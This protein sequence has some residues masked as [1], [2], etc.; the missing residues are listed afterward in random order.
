MLKFKG[1]ATEFKEYEDLLAKKDKLKKSI[2]NLS[3]KIQDE[4]DALSV[5]DGG[6]SD[7][8]MEL[9]RKHVSRRSELSKKRSVKQGNFELVM[10]RIFELQGTKF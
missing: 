2:T 3:N 6:L 10:K 5:F 8:D 7:R 4:D 1:S 9:F